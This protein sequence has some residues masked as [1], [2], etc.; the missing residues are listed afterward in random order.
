MK[1]YKYRMEAFAESY[2]SDDG[3]K[4]FRKFRRDD[5]HTLKGHRAGGLYSKRVPKWWEPIVIQQFHMALAKKGIDF[6]S[7]KGDMMIRLVVSDCD[8]G[9]V[10]RLLI[11][12]I[13]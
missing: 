1:W 4:W 6:D 2:Y 5:C 7:L 3:K 13:V 10:K 8:K 12:K 11:R 9:K